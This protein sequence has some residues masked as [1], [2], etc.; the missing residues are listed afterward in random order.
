MR[1]VRSRLEAR[2][3][4]PAD[5][6]LT[7]AQIDM[8][9]RVRRASGAARSEAAAARAVGASQAE[10]DWVRAR[11][12]EALL[13]LDSRRATAAVLESYGR[14][15][16]TLRESRRGAVDPAAARRVDGEIAALERE[17][18]TLR[19]PDPLL[20]VVAANAARVEKRRSEIEAAGP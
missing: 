3:R 12:V 11:L 4:P 20:S 6:R 1:A 18:A 19:R 10:F 16:A 13:A 15:I 8:Y 2:Y 5:G 14:A 7:D 9:L 17:R